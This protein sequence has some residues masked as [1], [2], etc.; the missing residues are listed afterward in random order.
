MLDYFIFFGLLSAGFLTFIF[1]PKPNQSDA[2]IALQIKCESPIERRLYDAL[3]RN[4]YRV[5]KHR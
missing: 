5:W 3:V 4:G 2:A 1:R